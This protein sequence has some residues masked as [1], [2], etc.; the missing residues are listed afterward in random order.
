MFFYMG[1]QKQQHMHAICE[2]YCGNKYYF[3]LFDQQTSMLKQN[4]LKSYSDEGSVTFH[5][6]VMYNP[7]L[8]FVKGFFLTNWILLNANQSEI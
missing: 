7:H 4:P 6:H 2:T 3:F 1:V 5:F 8:I